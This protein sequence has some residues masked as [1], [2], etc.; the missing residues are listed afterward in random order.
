MVHPVFSKKWEMDISPPF[1]FYFSVLAMARTA[2]YPEAREKRIVL[3]VSN[4]TASF[5]RALLLQRAEETGA[6]HRCHLNALNGNFFSR[7]KKSFQFS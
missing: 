6:D 7:L 3:S 4:S 5:L 1:L 2:Y